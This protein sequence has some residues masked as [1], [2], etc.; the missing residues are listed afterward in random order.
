MSDGVA[1]DDLDVV[2]YGAT[3]FVGRLT[4]DHLVRHAPRGTRIGLA[5]RSEKKLE[6]LRRRLGVRA[7]KWP[8]IVADADDPA[9]LSAMAKRT[10]VVASTVGP[11]AAYGLPLVQACAE[12]GTDYVDLTGEVL[13]ARR[14]IDAV[15]ELAQRTGARIVHSCGYDSIPS[16]LAVRAAARAAQEDGAEGIGD[17]TT[18]ATLKGGFSGGTIASARRQAEE[19]TADPSLRSIVTDKFALSPDRSAERSG[20]FRDV[21]SVHFSEE[22]DSWVAPFIMASYNTRVVRRS[23]A[24]TGH[25]YGPDFR[26]QEVMR[27]GDGVQ[28]SATAYAVAAGLGAGLAALSLP[29]LGP[30]VDRIVPGP[31]EGPHDRKRAAGFFRMDVRT[32]GSNGHRYRGVVAA[33]GDPGYAATSV[34]FAESALSLALEGDRCPLPQGRSGGVL[35]P[36]TALGDVLVDRLRAQGF[37]ITGERLG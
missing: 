14:S 28:G 6:K 4:A 10:K 1:D 12:N 20:E 29:F 21:P 35:T 16:D 3:G 7:E 34:M 15:D 8:I 2:L 37:T 5:G 32:T 11:Y 27:T 30:L 24:L 17:T 13:F 31:G 19:M 25:S 26:Y 23:N 9:A 33:Q 18:Y 22:A 36:A